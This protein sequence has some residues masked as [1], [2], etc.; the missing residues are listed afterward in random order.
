MSEAR[1]NRPT[2]PLSKPRFEFD[3]WDYSFKFSVLATRSLRGSNG[4]PSLQGATY[5]KGQHLVQR[6]REVLAASDTSQLIEFAKND[7]K[8]LEECTSDRFE[9][10]SN[11]WW[12]TLSNVDFVTVSRGSD[13]SARIQTDIMPSA[14]QNKPHDGA[15]P[16]SFIVQVEGLQE[17]EYKLKRLPFAW[18]NRNGNIHFGTDGDVT[19]STGGADRVFKLVDIYVA[20][21]DKRIAALDRAMTQT[22]HTLAGTI[23]GTTAPKS[24]VGP[25]PASA[26]RAF[27][28]KLT[29]I[30]LSKDR[31]RWDAD[32]IP[33]AG[34]SG[35]GRQAPTTATSPA[36]SVSHYKVDPATFELAQSDP[37]KPSMFDEFS[38]SPTGMPTP[39]IL[40]IASQPS[41]RLYWNLVDRP[42]F[43]L[44]LRG[45]VTSRPRAASNQLTCHMP[46]QHFLQHAG[47]LAVTG[48]NRMIE[49]NGSRQGSPLL[50]SSGAANRQL[51][52]TL[53]SHFATLFH[54]HAGKQDLAT[55]H[56]K[57][58]AMSTVCDKSFNL[59]GDPQLRINWTFVRS[60]TEPT[61]LF[62]GDL[63]S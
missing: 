14:Y 54:A 8:K 27:S 11:E 7:W 23:S 31:R 51:E 45:S 44:T 10:A 48:A 24:L 16:L 13:R 1:D 6:L 17:H 5:E 19:S 28:E 58:T 3:C 43:E 36:P 52:A 29:E 26:V 35:A 2:A 49:V 60:N 57:A 53:L 61:P 9:R 46:T 39:P 41:L 32:T 18:A 40:S 21:D 56:K 4:K 20:S 47:S 30:M 55:P 25:L 59:Q 38:V 62:V 33:P 12:R 22:I 50:W 63:A 34:T 37:A 42:V 15:R